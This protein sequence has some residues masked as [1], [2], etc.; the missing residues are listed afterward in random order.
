MVPYSGHVADV[1]T[2]FAGGLRS[3]LGYNGCRSIKELRERGIFRRITASGIREAH[4]HDIRIS[5]E[6][7]N[8]HSSSEG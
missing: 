7:P 5:K 2:Q 1:L 6:A 8:Y 4:P 3:S